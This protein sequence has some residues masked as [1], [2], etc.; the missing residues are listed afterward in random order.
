[1]KTFKVSLN[2]GGASFIPADRWEK[3]GD[4]YKF[5]REGSMIAEFAAPWV[6]K[7]EER[8]FP[9]DNGEAAK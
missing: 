3:D 9:N 6:K 8:D 5:Y 4:W 7:I 2:I 1:M